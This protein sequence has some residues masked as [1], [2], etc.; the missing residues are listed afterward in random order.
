MQ[1][2]GRD[3]VPGIDLSLLFEEPEKVPGDPSTVSREGREKRERDG[4]NG[5]VQVTK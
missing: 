1:G 5:R 3:A 2:E 4:R